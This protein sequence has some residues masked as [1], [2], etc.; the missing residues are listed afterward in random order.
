MC[1]KV[2]AGG[3][4]AHCIKI[5]PFWATWVTGGALGGQSGFQVSPEL[6]LEARAS[7]F[8]AALAVGQ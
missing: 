1:V 6:F 5:P 4:S 7:F 2:L 3:P 8:L